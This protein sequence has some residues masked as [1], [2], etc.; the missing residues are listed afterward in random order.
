MAEPKKINRRSPRVPREPRAGGDEKTNAL[1]QA[2]ALFPSLS[3]HRQ[4]HSPE[5]TERDPLV[6]SYTRFVTKWEGKGKNKQKKEVP[7]SRIVI[8]QRTSAKETETTTSDPWEALQQ[9][10]QS[11][12]QPASRVEAPAFNIGA[13]V[14]VESAPRHEKK[15]GDKHDPL[16]VLGVTFESTVEDGEEQKPVVVQYIGI[17]PSE[18]QAKGEEKV[19]PPYTGKVVL[20]GKMKLTR[21]D[22]EQE[23]TE[24]RFYA[25]NA[26]WKEKMKEGINGAE[27]RLQPLQAW[28]T[29]LKEIKSKQSEIQAALQNEEA[30]EEVKNNANLLLEL[31][32]RFDFILGIV[33]ID[34]QLTTQLP[35]ATFLIEEYG[36]LRSSLS[37]AFNCIRKLRAALSLLPEGI[38][39]PLPADPNAPTPQVEAEPVAPTPEEPEVEDAVADFFETLPQEDVEGQE[40]DAPQLSS[41][42]VNRVTQELSSA[43]LTLEEAKK[44]AERI[45]D[46]DALKNVVAQAEVLLGKFNQYL[47]QKTSD[48][49]IQNESN[50]L[51]LGKQQEAS[52]EFA[53]YFAQ[54]QTLHAQVDEIEQLTT[55]LEQLTEAHENQQAVKQ[56]PQ[57]PTLHADVITPAPPT[58]AL[59]VTVETGTDVGDLP[60]LS[61]VLEPETSELQTAAPEEETEVPVPS[62][63]EVK[64]SI[65]G[66][67]TG[68]MRGFV[69][70]VRGKNLPREQTKQLEQI[71]LN[72]QKLTALWDKFP[73]DPEERRK[74]F[75]SL[76]QEDRTCAQEIDALCQ[77]SKKATKK[78]PT[79]YKEQKIAAFT[80]LSLSEQVQALAQF[81][82]QL[83]RMY[84]GLTT[85]LSRFNSGE[86]RVNDTEMLEA[87]THIENAYQDAMASMNA[88]RA[89]WN[90]LPQDVYVRR[91]IRDM[92]DSFIRKIPI[93]PTDMTANKFWDVYINRLK[94]SQTYMADGAKV[95]LWQKEKKHMEALRLNLLESVQRFNDQRGERIKAAWQQMRTLA[96]QAQ[97]A[98]D[99]IVQD[100]DGIPQE[101][102]RKWILENGR[103]SSE[104]VEFYL[105]LMT[106]E[107]KSG[108]VWEGY[109]NNEARPRVANLPLETQE[110]Q[111]QDEINRLAY[112]VSDLNRI[113]R[114]RN[115]T[116]TFKGEGNKG[117]GNGSEDSGSGGRRQKKKG[118]R[119]GGWRGKS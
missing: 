94:A 91:A 57:D 106:R 17:L 33:K 89:V 2:D 61:D 79:V 43:M 23:T 4:Q 39:T 93:L 56:E 76:H 113:V 53:A 100:A 44:K 72:I 11:I 29:Y 85:A 65:L 62:T 51:M 26:D 24:E 67:L 63:P 68:M 20:L 115:S 84:L 80:E 88:F 81:K 98:W 64:P 38:I 82:N 71:D 54:W 69:D 49:S 92:S 52:S 111:L 47:L 34:A 22:Q 16:A 30:F 36:E 46:N 70:T 45:K 102:Q 59:T 114:Y 10:L 103:S 105:G 108:N 50:A 117:S 5:K 42:E 8:D 107:K 83:E 77:V 6:F 87:V 41:A 32:E 15:E 7:V 78:G 73:Q 96:D 74:L 35:T 110:H 116:P 99:V 90:A 37:K 1:R 119:G 55:A 86:L 66:R 14:Q 58:E 21:F 18:L 118:S 28:A 31:V 48:R 13:T 112:I 19:F 3:E 27:L 101:D 97:E 12:K 9:Q 95:E 25:I 75:Y 109:L 60:V 40:L 104:L